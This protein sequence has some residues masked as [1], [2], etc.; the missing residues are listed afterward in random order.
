MV[1]SVTRF[2]VSLE[3]ELLEQFDAH[4]TRAGYASRSEGLRDLVREALAQEELE[5]EVGE[6]VGTLTLLYDHHAPGLTEQ[7]VARQHDHHAQVMTT[8][9][10]HVDHHTCLEILVLKGKAHEVRS[11]GASLRAIKGVKLG[12][13]IVTPVKDALERSAIALN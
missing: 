11:L 12:K 2:G 6:V 13:L 5:Q 3:R 8:T 9:H 4:L 1:E 10:I 7:L